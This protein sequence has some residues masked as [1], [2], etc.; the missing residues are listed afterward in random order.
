MG[1]HLINIISIIFIFLTANNCFAQN[2]SPGK[3]QKASFLTDSTKWSIEVPMWIPGFRGE[4]TY[5][6]I[7]LEGEDGVI[8]EPENPIEKPGFGDAFKR[9]FRTSGSLNYF[10]ISAVS[11][12][13]NRY[14][15]EMDLF[16]GSIGGKLSFRYNNQTLVKAKVDGLLF[17][18][19]GGY[20][21]YDT[22]ILNE[23]AK[24]NLY[25]YVG[26]RFHNFEIESSL[27]KV[28][29][30]L[31]IDPF[32]VEPILGVK[33]ELL[34]N[35]WRFV[36]QADMGSFGVDRKMSYLLNFFTYYKLSN[37]L[38]FKLGW[39]TWYINYNDRYR[40]EKLKLKV[41]LAGPAGSLAFTF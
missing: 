4:F 31:D 38:T 34:F 14:L 35:R 29:R 32:W 26:L 8:P 3:P 28:Q 25:G 2:S 36:A 5:G 10:F 30:Q 17:R 12:K 1:K 19:I 24:Y 37:L 7:D 41:H 27:D 11:Y 23:K 13:N 16:A 9:L 33:N 22:M 39:N 18:V 40:N 6:D 20:N 15:G 21:F